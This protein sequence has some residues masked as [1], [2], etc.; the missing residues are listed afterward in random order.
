VKKLWR[1]SNYCD[2]SGIGGERYDA[3]WHTAARGRR[4][5]YLAEHPALALVE[6]LVNLKSDPSTFPEKYQ[7]IE[8]DVEER[9][10]DACQA[11]GKSDWLNPAVAVTQAFGDDWLRSRKSALLAVPSFPSPM[12]TNYLLNPLH[13]D[14]IGIKVASCKWIEYDQRLFR[15]RSG[16][17]EPI[18]PKMRPESRP[19]PLK[20]RKEKKAT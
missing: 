19:V 17:F 20:R 4:I 12:S 9:V 14:A 10:M 16:Q 5:V 6:V 8:I 3:R 1:I 18:E 15:V 11:F 7:L 2:L 13:P